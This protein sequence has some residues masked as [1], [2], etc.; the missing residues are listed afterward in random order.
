MDGGVSALSDRF[1]EGIFVECH[2][3]L[4]LYNSSISL[5][6]GSIVERFWDVEEL[7]TAVHVGDASEVCRS[8]F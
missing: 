8:D 2:R 7:A 3:D 1:S 5:L 6:L 4:R